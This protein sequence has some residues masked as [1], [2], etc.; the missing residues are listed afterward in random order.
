M[1]FPGPF[2]YHTPRGKEDRTWVFVSMRGALD[3]H[4]VA[5]VWRMLPIFLV[6]GLFAAHH[7]LSAFPA[8]ELELP[9]QIQSFL[10]YCCVL[11]ASVV[12]QTDTIAL[13]LP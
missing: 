11:H 4:K 8:I 12:A 13:P 2:S 6:W 7:L 5:A 3:L 1:S 9:V 10:L